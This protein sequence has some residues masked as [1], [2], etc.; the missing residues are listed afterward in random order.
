MLVHDIRKNRSWVIDFR[1]V[2]PLGIPLER[3]L[4]QDTKVRT[5]IP[6]PLPPGLLSPAFL[7]PV[8]RLRGRWP[9]KQ[10]EVSLIMGDPGP[11]RHGESRENTSFISPKMPA[12]LW[13]VNRRIPVAAGC[14][15]NKDPRKEHNPRPFCGV[16][17]PDQTGL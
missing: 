9:A 2:A 17:S 10:Q 7:P 13:E 8:F 3:D 4:Q 1:E 6:Q 14:W 12:E 11:Y 15:H 5:S 16:L